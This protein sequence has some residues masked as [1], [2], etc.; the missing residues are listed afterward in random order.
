[1]GFASGV[2]VEN[3]KWKM[4]KSKE[5]RGA[6][7]QRAQRRSTEYTEKGPGDWVMEEFPS[8]DKLRGIFTQQ[9]T[10]EEEDYRV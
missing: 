4:E 1:M 3:R 6:L 10:E 7:T 2:R 8:R 5:K 9:K